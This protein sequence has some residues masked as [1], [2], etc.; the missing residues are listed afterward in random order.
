MKGVYVLVHVHMLSLRLVDELERVL[1]LHLRLNPRRPEL[2]LTNLLPL[3]LTRYPLK[4]INNARH[5][6]V[7]LVILEWR[8]IP[9]CADL[10]LSLVVYSLLSLYQFGFKPLYPVCGLINT[11]DCNLLFSLI[12]QHTVFHV[13]R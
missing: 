9:Q 10:L 13:I 4:R 7:T 1:I 11:V 2:H 8:E 3:L 5:L 12:Q 6:V